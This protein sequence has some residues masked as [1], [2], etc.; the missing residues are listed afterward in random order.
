METPNQIIGTSV[1][2]ARPEVLDSMPG[3]FN[4]RRTIH[5]ARTVANAPLN[6]R[7]LQQLVIPPATTILEDGSQFLRYDNHGLVSRFLIFTTDSNLAALT[8]SSSWFADGTFSSVP[9]ALFTQ[10]YTIHCVHGIY[11]FILIY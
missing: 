9:T 6:P 10:L 1:G 2:A 3:M 5:R 4:I 7:T 11:V 8:R